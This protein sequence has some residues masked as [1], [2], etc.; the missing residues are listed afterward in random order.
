MKGSDL[1][2]ASGEAAKRE[3]QV[4]LLKA[5]TEHPAWP[6]SVY[7][8]GMIPPSKNEYERVYRHWAAKRDL[9]LLWATVLDAQL[10]SRAI[11]KG[12][13]KDCATLGMPVI[14][15]VQIA[16]RRLLDDTAIYAGFEPIKDVLTLRHQDGL[17]W[18]ADDRPSKCTTDVRQIKSDRQG[19][20]IIIS[21]R[22]YK[23][24]REP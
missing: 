21:P 19:T 8:D 16:R 20:R 13:L 24:V 6:I 23:K 7:V 22:L 17:G 4:D 11:E 3:Q 2:R 1:M 9:R 18:I 10:S 15:Q 5:L 14:L 12:L